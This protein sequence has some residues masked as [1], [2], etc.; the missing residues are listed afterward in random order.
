MEECNKKLK[1]YK[2]IGAIKRW[3]NAALYLYVGLASLT[4]Q[5]YAALQKR[6][7]ENSGLKNQISVF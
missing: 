1:F 3:M 5:I 6:K 2:I 7:L 4:T